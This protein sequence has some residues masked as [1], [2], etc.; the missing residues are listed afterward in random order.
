M[1]CKNNLHHTFSNATLSRLAADSSIQEPG[2]W[3]LDR[4]LRHAASPAQQCSAPP[5]GETR[6]PPSPASLGRAGQQSVSALR[7]VRLEHQTARKKPRKN[8]SSSRSRRASPSFLP[9]HLSPLNPP[10]PS[11]CSTLAAAAPR[12]RPSAPQRY[13]NVAKAAPHFF[14][15]SI[16]CE[17]YNTTSDESNPSSRFFLQLHVTP[18]VR[19]PGVAQQRRALS[20]HEYLSADLLR[21]VITSPRSHA[22][23]ASSRAASG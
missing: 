22:L 1:T 5:V 19:L 13:G 21:K 6:V 17:K 10:S 2:S 8:V 4:A 18:S 9:S 14:N 3:Q 15:P 16:I 7:A 12:R 20:I 23:M 11:T